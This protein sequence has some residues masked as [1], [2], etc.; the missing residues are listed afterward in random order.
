MDEQD[1]RGLIAIY[2]QKA[3]DFFN[4]TVA[5]ETR[6]DEGANSKQKSHAYNRIT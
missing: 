3:Q 6:G 5:A 2:Q 4:P 1:Y